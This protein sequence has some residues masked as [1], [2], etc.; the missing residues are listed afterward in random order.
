[1]AEVFTRTLV[2]EIANVSTRWRFS[3]WGHEHSISDSR[4]VD[5]KVTE[6]YRHFNPISCE[7]LR[8]SQFGWHQ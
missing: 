2:A 1:M 4:A 6:T 5:P 8:I 3:N 7:Y